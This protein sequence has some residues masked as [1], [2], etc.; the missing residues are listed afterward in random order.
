MQRAIVQ[1]LVRAFLR[2][3]WAYGRRLAGSERRYHGQVSSTRS[4]K[5]DSGSL[6]RRPTATRSMPRSILSSWL[7]GYNP[8]S[9]CHSIGIYTLPHCECRSTSSGL[10]LRVSLADAIAPEDETPQQN[11]LL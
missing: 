11:P 7:L 10:F 9:Q 8:C 4:R 5:S 3:S 1:A 6:Y 2:R